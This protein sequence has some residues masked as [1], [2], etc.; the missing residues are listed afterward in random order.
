MFDRLRQTKSPE[1]PAWALTDVEPWV[2]PSARA[3]W[4]P[5][6]V[7]RRQRLVRS[8]IVRTQQSSAQFRV[9]DLDRVLRKQQGV[10]ESSS[11][12]LMFLC[13][14]E[15]ASPSSAA[16]EWTTEVPDGTLLMLPAAMDSPPLL[17]LNDEELLSLTRWVQSLP[18]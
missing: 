2:G 15:A 4:A 5:L 17:A 11:S 13:W 7:G 16:E 8:V 3:E 6:A 10:A 12:P 14:P 18:A 9:S 1:P